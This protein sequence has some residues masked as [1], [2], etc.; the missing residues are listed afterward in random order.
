MAWI[1]V[2]WCKIYEMRCERAMR[3][4]GKEKRMESQSDAWSQNPKTPIY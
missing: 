1:G 3:G 2:E 4:K